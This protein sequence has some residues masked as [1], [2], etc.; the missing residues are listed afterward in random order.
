MLKILYCIKH[1]SEFMKTEYQL[2]ICDISGEHAPICVFVSDS[3]FPCFMVG[4]RFDDEGWQR[5]DGTVLG[6]EQRPIRFSI[7]SIKHILTVKNG[8][9]IVQTGLNLEPFTGDR[10][11]AFQEDV[12]MTWSKALERRK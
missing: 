12:A 11:P 7:H 1:I 9:N 3:P 2:F 8:K 10:S 5:L 6:S 4:D